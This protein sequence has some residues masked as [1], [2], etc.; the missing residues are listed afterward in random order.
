M[1]HSKCLLKLTVVCQHVLF[2]SVSL[3]HKHTHSH[4]HVHVHTQ[5]DTHTRI[6]NPTKK[7]SDSLTHTHTVTHSHTQHFLSFAFARW[8][9]LSWFIGLFFKRNPV[10]S[11]FHKRDL[12]NRKNRS[13]NKQEIRGPIINWF[14]PWLWGF[15]RCHDPF[16][17]ICLVTQY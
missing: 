16:R 15:C 8:F 9:S 4:V 14:M 5:I 13:R 7:H 17:V 1:K 6:D 10:V 3:S 2:L 11:I 12:I